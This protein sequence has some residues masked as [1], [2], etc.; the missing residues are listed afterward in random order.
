LRQVFADMIPISTA[1]MLIQVDAV[2]DTPS[3][4]EDG[5]VIGNAHDVSWFDLEPCA[6]VIVE[7][8]NAQRHVI[9]LGAKVQLNKDIVGHDKMWPLKAALKLKDG[10]LIV[11]LCVQCAL[12]QC[13]DS[14]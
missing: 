10:G 8:M 1:E 13:I 3:L 5:F 7:E 4:E 14:Q 11:V 9:A 6:E 2:C 12:R